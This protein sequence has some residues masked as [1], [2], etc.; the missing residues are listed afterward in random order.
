MSK[1][2]FAL[3]DWEN[4]FVNNFMEYFVA[5]ALDSF[6]IRVL[7]TLKPYLATTRTII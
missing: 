1:S 4:R 5:K 7:R 3:C 2:V 6:D